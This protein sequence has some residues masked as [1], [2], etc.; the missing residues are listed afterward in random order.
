M[1]P[2]RSP[3]TPKVNSKQT[4]AIM[5]AAVIQVSC[6]PWAFRSSWK[7]PFSEAGSAFAT[8]A[9]KTAAQ[10]AASVPA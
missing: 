1:R 5:N 6:V 2:K 9:T 4:T 8:W 7:R 10:A 3:R